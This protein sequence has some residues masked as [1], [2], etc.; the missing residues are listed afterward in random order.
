MLRNAHYKIEEQATL[1][2]LESA[3]KE[4]VYRGFAKVGISKQQVR[5]LVESGLS[6]NSRYQR[7]FTESAGFADF[8]TQ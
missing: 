4:G 2:D 3:M 6:S 8:I 1:N 5:Q 7:E